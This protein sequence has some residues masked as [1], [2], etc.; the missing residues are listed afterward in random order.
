MGRALI[1][2]DLDR[3]T[4]ISHYS[5]PNSSENC[6]AF[7]QRAARHKPSSQHYEYLPFQVVLPVPF[8]TGSG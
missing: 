2:A 8:D 5:L 7:A 1:V 6:D 3:A 4:S